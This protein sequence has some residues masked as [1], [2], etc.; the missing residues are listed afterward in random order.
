MVSEELLLKDYLNFFV[1]FQYIDRFDEEN[2]QNMPH[3]Y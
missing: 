2:W 1:S 3:K